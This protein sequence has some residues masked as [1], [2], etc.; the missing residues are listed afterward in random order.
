MRRAAHGKK[1]FN[2]RQARDGFYRAVSTR[3]FANLY[4]QARFNPATGT[5][6]RLFWI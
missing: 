6:G 3:A 5:V 1:I 4:P 2:S